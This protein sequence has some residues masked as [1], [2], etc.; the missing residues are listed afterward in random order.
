ML[1]TDIST[2]QTT[3]ITDIFLSFVSVWVIICLVRNGYTVDRKKTLIWVGSFGLLSLAAVLGAF[4]HG[5][6][7][8]EKTNEMIWQPLNLFLGL[9]VAF[10][11]AGVIYDLNRFHI[12]VVTL[13]IILCLGVIFFGITFIVPGSFFV[14]IL[15]EAA[16]MIFA[17]VAYLVLAYK[18]QLYGAGFMT[19]GILI[20]IIAAIVQASEQ[21]HMKVIWEFDHNG[22]FHIIQMIGLLFLYLGLKIEFKSR[23]IAR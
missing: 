21:I 5:I 13:I 17:L 22:L 14:F 3:A 11:T 6:K 23:I 8:P 10:F 2:E 19:F 4:A 7:M 9:S 12:K 20:S 16:V 15:Y 1:L 18:K